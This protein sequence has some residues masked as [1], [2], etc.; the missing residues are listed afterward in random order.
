M[1]ALGRQGNRVIPF[2]AGAT[3]VLGFIRGIAFGEIKG[4]GDLGTPYG[5]S[6]MTGLVVAVATFA[7][8]QWVTGPAAERVSS[9][10]ASPQEVGRVRLYAL[11]ELVGFFVIFTTMILMHFAP[12]G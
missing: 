1:R 2:V 11:L 5:L 7:W 3:I 4:V 8:G 12:E 6:W 9:G 10:N